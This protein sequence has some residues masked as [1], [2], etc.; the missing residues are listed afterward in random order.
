ML[1]PPECDTHR[2]LSFHSAE[3]K[4]HKQSSVLVSCSIGLVKL[5]PYFINIILMK[6]GFPVRIFFFQL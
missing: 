5:R 1:N 3:I 2:D 4:L 6:A